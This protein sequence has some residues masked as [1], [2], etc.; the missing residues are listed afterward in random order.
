M[1]KKQRWIQ[2]TLI[3][4]GLFLFVVTYLYYPRMYED[5]L[6]KDQSITEDFEKILSQGE[7]TTFENLEYKGIYDLDKPFK[8][9]SEKA[10]ILN[11]DPDIVYM[12]NMHVIL[13]LNDERIV[14]ITSDKGKYN[15]VTYDCFFE[16]NVKAT[17]GSTNIFAENMDLLATKNFAIIYNN[18]NLNYTTGYLLADKIDYDFETKNFK[19]SM[20]DDKA[21]KMKVIQ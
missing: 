2:L 6:L 4:I 16:Q 10:Y 12:Q 18:V 14:N 17:D 9:K 7:S 5:K 20:F 13:Y 3:S 19:V 15:K 11:E 8:V 1:K 21:I